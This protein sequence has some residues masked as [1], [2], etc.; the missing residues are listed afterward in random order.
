[1]CVHK[2]CEVLYPFFGGLVPPSSFG[3]LLEVMCPT[4]LR[5]LVS[6]LLL[7]PIGGLI[8]GFVSL[9]FGRFCA[10]FFEDL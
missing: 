10:P 9:N 8:G 3:D 7:I 6:L 4:I 5:G 2:F 1:M